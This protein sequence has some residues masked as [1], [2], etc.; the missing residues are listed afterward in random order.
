M[1]DKSLEQI[2]K[3]IE[4][5]L[6]FLEN[7]LIRTPIIII[8]ILFNSAVIPSV[9]IELAKIF[10]YPIVK[11]LMLLVILYVCV[12]DTAVAM[13]L[14]IALVISV[15][16]GNNISLFTNYEDFAEEE[17]HPDHK[18]ESHINDEDEDKHHENFTMNNKV[19]EN[20]SEQPLGYNAKPNCIA[21]CYSGDNKRSAECSPVS[22]FT[23]ELNA[24]GLN[25]PSGYEGDSSGSPWN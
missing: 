9:N 25:C 17:P 4:N 14:A 13:L 7:P 12:K 6:G 20:D 5:S 8:L 19:P 3:M 10:N 22:T 2:S 24:Q 15:Q 23:N 18:E 21:D 11:L 1:K 16:Y